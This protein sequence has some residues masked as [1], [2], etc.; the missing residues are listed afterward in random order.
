[1]SKLAHKLCF[2]LLIN[3]HFNFCC[4][5]ALA[6]TTLDILCAVFLYNHYSSGG[7][8]A[9]SGGQPKRQRHRSAGEVS[10]ETAILCSSVHRK[11]HC[12]LQLKC[13]K[14]RRAQLL[15]EANRISCLT[16]S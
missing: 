3:K 8:G 11:R 2:M 10:R 9:Q 16:C 4:F 13:F 12:D 14:R 1:M 5:R 15:S 6:Y 7:P